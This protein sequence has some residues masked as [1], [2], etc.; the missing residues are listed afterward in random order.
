MNTSHAAACQA[1]Q[2]I[3]PLRREDNWIISASSEFDVASTQQIRNSRSGSPAATS[4]THSLTSLTS[5][6]SG[7]SLSG[8]GSQAPASRARAPR[9]VSFKID[10]LGPV[11]SEAS[12][13]IRVGALCSASLGPFRDRLLAEPHCDTNEQPASPIRTTRA[14]SS[15]SASSASSDS[16]LSF[17]F[18]PAALEGS[19]LELARS[20]DQR[21]KAA[22]SLRTAIKLKKFECERK[23]NQSML[24]NGSVIFHFHDFCY[25]HA[26][27]RLAHFLQRYA[28]TLCSNANCWRSS[29]RSGSAAA[30]ANFALPMLSNS[31]RPGDKA[32]EWNPSSDSELL[33]LECQRLQSLYFMLVADVES[34]AHRELNVNV[35]Q[36]MTH[37]QCYVENDLEV[38][39]RQLVALV[40]EESRRSNP[41]Y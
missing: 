8:H 19:L 1:N 37:L 15:Q 10:E 41:M 2:K 32:L 40:N 34:H 39:I 38:F 20:H 21:I 14:R 4:S 24:T 30:T 27:L 11:D 31:K 9:R 17:P 12:E 25:W 29:P 6:A 18:S 13:H 22:T 23:I 26:Q 7:S 16:D 36:L 35:D 33:C 3:Q 5:T 28:Q